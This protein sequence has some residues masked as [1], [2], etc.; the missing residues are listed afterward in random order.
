MTISADEFMRRFLLH[1]LPSGFQRIR[2]YGLL[3]NGYR[4]ENL[5]KVRALLNPQNALIVTPI[6]KTQAPLD[7][8]VPKF[9]CA[10]CGAEMR[11]ID[12]FLRGQAIRAPPHQQRCP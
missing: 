5:T 7:H 2:H 8:L 10:H 4:Q 11:I 1:V 9:V 12:I 3:A 6:D